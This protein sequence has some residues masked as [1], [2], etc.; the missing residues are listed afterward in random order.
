MR[1]EAR[2]IG[3]RCSKLEPLIERARLSATALGSH[4]QG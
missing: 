3:R 1:F 4:L 2:G